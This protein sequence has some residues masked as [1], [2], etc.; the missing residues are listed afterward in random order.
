VGAIAIA[1]LGSIVVHLAAF[2]PLLFGGAVSSRTLPPL[3]MGAA[4]S[5]THDS[6]N[7]LMT[8]FVNEALSPDTK[9][10]QPAVSE[11]SFLST[12][13][14]AEFLKGIAQPTVIFPDP[15]PEDDRSV[16]SAAAEAAGD[17]S[18]RALMFGRYLGQIM[19]R[20]SR[21]W[22]RPRSA[23]ASGSFE[24][25]VQ[26]SQDARGNV[27]EIELHECAAD[28]PWQLSLVHAIE[29]ASPL[30]AP[31]DPSVF[32][33][34][35]VLDFDSPQYVAGASEDGFEPPSRVANIA[36]PN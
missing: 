21:A 13:S 15:A 18:G 1:A 12:V 25:R 33:A 14:I 31:P 6:S 32:S 11:S 3:R 24:C 35:L 22:R 34:T 4:A 29:S 9:P 26:I 20:V 23:I 17:Q 30:P 36:R 27:G 8:L 2:A 5:A 28:I 10:A 16:K 19:A 7:T